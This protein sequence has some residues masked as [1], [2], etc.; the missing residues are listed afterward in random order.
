MK[1]LD[2]FAGLG[3]FSAGFVG[4][5]GV[6]VET[7]DNG[8]DGAFAVTHA[9]DVADFHGRPGEFDVI[10]S[11]TPCT[12]YAKW[13]MRGCLFSDR[14]AV[15]YPDNALLMHTLRIINE[16]QPRVY[17]VENVI[18]AVAFISRYLGPPAITIGRRYFW[19][20]LS[21]NKSEVCSSWYQRKTLRTVRV[22]GRDGKARCAGRG[23]RASAKERSMIERPISDFFYAKCAAEMV[24][25]PAPF[26]PVSM[27]ESEPRCAVCNEFMHRKNWAAFHV[28]P[29]AKHT[30]T[31]CIA[32]DAPRKAEV[33]AKIE[34]EKKV[35]RLKT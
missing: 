29:D 24:K 34:L 20:N 25:S 31:I 19:S 22:M 8:R 26:T 13:M 9:M 2:L 30:S 32:C 17:V 5:E 27:A 3:G 28:P 23:W 33:L 12:E 6:T 10:L 16:V 4:R 7:L 11:G 18:G 14:S 1:V 35:V 15:A 21:I